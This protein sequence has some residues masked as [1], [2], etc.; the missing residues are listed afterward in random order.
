MARI[1]DNIISALN[2]MTVSGE[3]VT[4]DYERY[5]LNIDGR[6]PYIEV[7]GPYCENEVEIDSTMDTKVEFAIKYYLDVND[8]SATADTEVTYIMRNVSKDIIKQVMLDQ[9]RNSLAEYT[10]VTDYGLAFEVIDN[11]VVY[12]VYVIVEVQALINPDNPY[13][14]G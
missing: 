2:G 8:E 12:F 6:Y 3:T 9:Q 5:Y 14:A 10:E 1:H 11:Q 7:L 4:A 13:L